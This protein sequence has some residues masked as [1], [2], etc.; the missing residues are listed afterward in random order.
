[1]KK[2]INPSTEVEYV[3]AMLA[4]CDTSSDTGSQPGT[5]GHAP[6]RKNVF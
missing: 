3:N 4:L 2:Y 6:A 5:S 1:M